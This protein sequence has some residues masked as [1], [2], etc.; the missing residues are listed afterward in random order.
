MEQLTRTKHGDAAGAPLKIYQDGDGLARAH[1]G[2]NGL[3]ITEVNYMDR[4]LSSSAETS[5]LR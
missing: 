4:A 5:P 1:A 2:L 3:R